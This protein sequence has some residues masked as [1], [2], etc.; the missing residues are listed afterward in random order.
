M[1][2]ATFQS[3]KRAVPAVVLAD[4]RLLD[5]PAGGVAAIEA[6]LLPSG[7]QLPASVL[8]IV[9]GGLPMLTVCRRLIEHADHPA[10]APH[11][12][13]KTAELLAPIPRPA[14]NVFC[15][16]KNYRAHISEGSVAQGIADVVPESPVFFTKPPTAVIGPD[17][18]ILR[19]PD[20]TEKLDYEVELAVVIGRRGRNIPAGD[21][22]DY[23]FGF[24]IINDISARDIQRQHGGQYFKGKGLDGSCPMGPYIVTRDEI[25]NVDD[26]RIALTVNGEIRQDGNTRDMIFSIPEQIAALSRGMTLEPGDLIATG[27]PSGVGYAMEPPQFLQHGDEVTCEVE[28]IGVLRNP[29]KNVDELAVVTG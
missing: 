14:K 21:A 29:V 26:L 28:G 19:Q 15:V 10:L 24:T 16:G 12:V 27:T 4:D 18:A 22:L 9:Q 6:D 17:E 20:I 5:I 1:R 23:I 25:A 7:A 13:S 8:D 2:F 11:V 3:G